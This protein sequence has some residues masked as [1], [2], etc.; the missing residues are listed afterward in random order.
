[1]SCLHPDGLHTAGEDDDLFLAGDA[2]ACFALGWNMM[3][4]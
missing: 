4:A 1:M 3:S 2:L